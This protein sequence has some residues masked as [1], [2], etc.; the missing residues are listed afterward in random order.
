M[1]LKTL[2]KMLTA[3]LRNNDQ[4][5]W[6]GGYVHGR[7][8]GNDPFIILYP[9]SE[10][11]NHKVCRVYPHDFKKLP[12]FVNTDVPEPAQNENPDKD[13]AIKRGLYF[14]CPNFLIVTYQG[15]ETTMGNEIRFSDVLYIPQTTGKPVEQEA[16]RR[17]GRTS[18]SDTS[19]TPNG[20]PGQ[21]VDAQLDKYFSYALECGMSPGAANVHL[22]QFGGNPLDALQALQVE[23][24]ERPAAQPREEADATKY[25]A[26]VY[27]QLGWSRQGAKALLDQYHGNFTEAYYHAMQHKRTP[28]PEP[29]A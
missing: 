2:E 9:A 13:K 21:A 16:G 26:F 19:D 22:A 20:K 12:T 28:D 25:Y 29:G 4:L 1:D 8:G 27:D 18:T 10:L 24:G 6:I 15:R 7:T 11:L 23:H 14:S 17:T 3:L 5:H